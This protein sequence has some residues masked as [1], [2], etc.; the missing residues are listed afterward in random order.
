MSESRFYHITREGKLVRIA[1]LSEVLAE[2]QNGGFV[3]L[4]YTQPTKEELSLLIEPFGLHPLS[5]EDCLDENLIPKVDD[6]SRYTFFIFNAFNYTRQILTIREINIFLGT[7]FLITVNVSDS[8]NEQFLKSIAKTVE[9]NPKKTFQGPAF[10]LHVILDYI[11]DQKYAAIETFENDLDK[12][13]ET[14]I[15]DLS[16]FD[17]A[18]LLNLRRDLFAMR[19]SLFHEREIMV[20][21]YRKDFHLIP[22]K[23]L[24]YYRD[25]YDHLTKFFEMTETSRDVVTSLMEMYLSMLNN[26]MAETANRTNGTVRRLTF[27]TTIFMPLT[28]LAGIGGMSEWSMMTG[29]SNWKIAYPAFLFAMVVIG[30]ANYWLL[31]WLERKR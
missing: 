3:W 6:Y 26:K 30:F 21:I 13:E 12:A 14:V 22:E 20:K 25:I 28:L 19:R 17:P 4:D 9:I 16:N 18:T 31:K 7:D 10:L 23:A 8:N 11:V 15:A 2:T 5:I 24:F 1:T 27:I 29:P